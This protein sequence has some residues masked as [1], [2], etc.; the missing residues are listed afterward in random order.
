MPTSSVVGRCSGC[1]YIFRSGGTE[2]QCPYCCELDWRNVFWV[3]WRPGADRHFQL[4]AAGGPGT[5]TLE[6]EPM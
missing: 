4:V 1:G 6:I 2:I 5:F 3:L